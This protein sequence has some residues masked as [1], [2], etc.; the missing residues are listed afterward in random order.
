MW[1]TDFAWAVTIRSAMHRFPPCSAITSP[2]ASIAVACFTNSRNRFGATDFRRRDET[3]L[4]T[5]SEPLRRRYPIGAELIGQKETH[6]R[7]WAPKA[8]SLEVISEGLF[9]LRSESAQLIREPDGYFSGTLPV[10][11]GARYQFRVNGNPN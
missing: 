7:V 4:M 8:E 10:A 5:A 2:H 3:A 9:G 6:F 11:A 1:K